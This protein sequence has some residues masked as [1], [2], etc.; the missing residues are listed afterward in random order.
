MDTEEKKL[1]RSEIDEMLKEV[2]EIHRPR[3]TVNHDRKPKKKLRP[4]R[5]IFAV[6]LLVL[7]IV[8]VYFGYKAFSSSDKESSNAEGTVAGADSGVPLEDDQYPEITELVQNYLEAYLIENDEKRMNAFRE[9]VIDLDDLS[10]I[11]KRNYVSSYS[12]VE[13]YT[14]EGP[15]EDTFI[16]FAYYHTTYKNLSTSVP[17][18]TEFYV[19]R[20]G[21][22]QNV[23]IKNK[24][25]EDVR[26]YIERVKQDAD[27]K[28]LESEVQ[29][30]YEA[31]RAED[32]YLDKFLNDMA[33]KIS[34]KKE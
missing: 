17:S 32:E 18:I 5:I 7:I 11:K 27:V 8:A 14:K 3:R 15:Y 29:E 22:T 33:E 20:Q 30:E 19:M 16:V 2:E 34:E 6:V 26:A 12:D 31:V 23:Y 9:C 13:C 28:S 4:D 1:T 10:S 24:I 25:P 21:E